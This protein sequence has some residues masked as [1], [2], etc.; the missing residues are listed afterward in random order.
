MDCKIIRIPTHRVNVYLIISGSKAILVDPGVGKH[1]PVVY[2]SI[3]EHGLA[4]N[5]IKMLI[6]T[7]THYD[8]VDG[9]KEVREKTGARILVQS[10]EAESLRR[11]YTELPRGTILPGR[12]LS[13]LG[14]KLV[15][16]IGSYPPAVADILIEERYDITELDV[17][18]FVIHTPGHTRGSVSVIIDNEYAFV[19]DCMFGIF[20]RSILPPFA[21]DPAALMRS[22]QVLADT[23]C[24]TFYPGHGKSIDRQR[25]EDNLRKFILT[26][27]HGA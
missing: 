16:S 26:I 3:R 6:L 27:P 7:H 11:G 21:D 24:S 20:R 18:A 4:L 1:L 23:G 12:I 22:W 13:F 17:P 9:I 8:H 5:D 10:N 25:F 19:G 15:P 14:R 2:A